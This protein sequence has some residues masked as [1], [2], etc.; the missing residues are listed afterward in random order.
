M[1]TADGGRPAANAGTTALP[2]LALDTATS[3]PR[4]SDG[5]ASPGAKSATGAVNASPN[6]VTGEEA[7][8]SGHS[9]IAEIAEAFR[10]LTH[11]ADRVVELDAVQLAKLMKTH[12]QTASLDEVQELIR[13]VDQN[14]NGIINF[15]D[16][17]AMLSEPVPLDDIEEMRQAFYMLDAEHRGWIASADFTMLFASYGEQSSPEECEE[18]RRFADPHD[19]GRVDYNKFLSTLAFRLQERT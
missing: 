19:T 6:S 18:L 16:F 17:T 3:S 7:Q 8:Q 13:A 12:G 4:G 15:P 9:K 2:S 11:D 14:G 10:L 5:T 1:S